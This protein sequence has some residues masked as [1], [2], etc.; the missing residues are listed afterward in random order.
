MNKPDPVRRIARETGLTRSDAE[1]AVNPILSGIAGSL[2]Q[3]KA[4]GLSGFGTFGARR[5]PAR[6]GRNPGTDETLEISAS[7]AA[8][9]KVGKHLR[10]AVNAGKP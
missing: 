4:V 6:T 3:R 9:F 7:A 10:D 5:R 1:A 8:T 2:A